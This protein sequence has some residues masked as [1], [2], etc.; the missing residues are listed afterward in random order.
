MPSQLSFIAPRQPVKP[1]PRLLQRDTSPRDSGPQQGRPSQV[2]AS[3]LMLEDH[4][5]SSVG[6]DEP[7]RVRSQEEDH[8]D[9]ETG[10]AEN[11]R[12]NRDHEVSPSTRPAV[13]RPDPHRR[14]SPSPPPAEA[15]DDAKYKPHTVTAQGFPVNNK[16][17]K[18]KYATSIDN[19]GYLAGK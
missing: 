9:P 17:K 14:H 6:D 5:K 19:R 7:G 2:L 15:L 13:A 12:T 3:P 10:P 1:A 11:I 18:A 16:V 8:L 4:R